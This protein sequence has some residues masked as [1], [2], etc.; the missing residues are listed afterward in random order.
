MQVKAVDFV[1][2]GVSDMEKAL[3]FYRDILG[4]KVEHNHEGTWVEFAVGAMTL[5]LI[6][7]PWGKPPQPGYQGGGTVALAVDDVAAT[8]EELKA[9]GVAILVGFDDSP[10]CHM[11]QIADPDGNRLW[12]HWRK[13]GT[14]G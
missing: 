14:C 13:D 2:F 12:L 10:V 5:A 1:S 6:G 4:L 8:L 3:V 11:A 9:K 7:P